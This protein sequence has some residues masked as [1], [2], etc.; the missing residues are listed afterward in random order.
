M[1]YFQMVN[2]NLLYHSNL[3]HEVYLIH[4]H[5][6]LRLNSR[7]AAEGTYISA[8]FDGF[9]PGTVWHRINVDAYIPENTSVTVETATSDDLIAIDLLNNNVWSAPRDKNANP[10]PITEKISD[11]LVQSSPGRY[12]WVR[13][14]LTSTGKAT[15]SLRSIQILYPRFSYL[16][17]LP[18]VYRRDPDGAWFLDRFLAL[19]ERIFTGIENKYELFSKQINPDAAPLEIINWLA[20]LVDLSFDP[21]WPLQRRRDL[22]NRAMELYKKRGT[23]KGIADYIEIYTGTRPNIVEAYLQRPRE[24]TFLGQKGSV[25]G[26]PMHL[27]EVSVN[28]K[29]EEQILLDYAHRFTVMVYLTDEC[30]AEVLI[31]VVDRIV[32]VNKPAHTDHTLCPV[33]PNLTVGVQSTVG[34]DTVL[35]GRSAQGTR[36]SGCDDTNAPASPAGILGVDSILGERRPTYVRPHDF[37]I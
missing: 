35:G 7:F 26:C 2:N 6:R 3:L 12:L 11:Q 37:Q 32:E 4:F 28:T 9:V 21:S 18:R 27:R 22:V 20:C 24:A 31:P 1:F 17:L 15:P 29:P 14:T 5:V 33:Y 25:L 30:D 19:F 13:I 8:A 34:F 10:I 36:I 16:D 23:P